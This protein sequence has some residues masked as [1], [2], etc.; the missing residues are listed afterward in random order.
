MTEFLTAGTSTFV[1]VIVSCT[2]KRFP[3][4]KI[5]IP[6]DHLNP[7]CSG[8]IRTHKRVWLTRRVLE[9]LLKTGAFAATVLR[10]SDRIPS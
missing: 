2:N 6:Q 9:Y 3:T 8:I 4:Y 1:E 5:V 10:E 7:M